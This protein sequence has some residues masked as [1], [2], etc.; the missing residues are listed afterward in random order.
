MA[1]TAARLRAR[2]ELLQERQAHGGDPASEPEQLA[3]QQPGLAKQLLKPQGL[4]RLGSKPGP[5][6]PVSPSRER[7]ELRPARRAAG[8]RLW[9]R[10]LWQLF[11]RLLWPRRRLLPQPACGNGP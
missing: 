11:L 1:L 5:Q 9:R 4:H 7:E 6:G 8:E 2:P 3:W 10:R